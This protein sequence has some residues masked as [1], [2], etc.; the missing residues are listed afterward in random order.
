MNLPDAA[1]CYTTAVV[2]KQYFNLIN[3]IGGQGDDPYLK[4][5]KLSTIT[6]TTLWPV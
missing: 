3:E 1:L 4:L 5:N 2:L 6:N